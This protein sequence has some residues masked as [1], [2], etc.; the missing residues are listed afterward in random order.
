MS[1]LLKWSEIQSRVET[2]LNASSSPLGADGLV[3]ELLRLCA[4][5][6]QN[7]IE[8]FKAATVFSFLDTDLTVEGSASLGRLPPRTNPEEWYVVD[9]DSAEYARPR[10]ALS[11]WPWA[12]RHDLTDGRSRALRPG[13][14]CYSINPSDSCEFYVY[15]ALSADRVLNVTARYTKESFSDSDETTFPPASI[16]AFYAWVKSFM[17]SDMEGELTA[18]ARLKSGSFTPSARGMYESAVRDLNANYGGPLVR[19]V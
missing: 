6:I 15:P 18:S 10:V 3:D 7:R 13:T 11:P 8:S 9:S 12:F 5:D 17:L 19:R 16:P 4:I 2:L 14:R 1:D